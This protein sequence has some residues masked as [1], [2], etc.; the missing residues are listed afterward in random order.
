[1][2]YSTH[3]GPTRNGTVKDGSGANCGGPVLSQSATIAYTDTTAK[4]LFIIPAGSKV[5]DIKLDVITAFDAGDTNT[6][7][8]GSSTDGD[9]FV[10]GASVATEVHATATLVAANLASIV[11][12]GTT[13]MQVTATYIPAGTAAGEGSAIITMLYQMRN[14]DGTTTPAP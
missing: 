7:D 11:N 8:I 10:D 9:L 5:V 12:I 6:L 4:N 3:L 14:A 1:M 13:D 2:T